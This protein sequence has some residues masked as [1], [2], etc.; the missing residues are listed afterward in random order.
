MAVDGTGAWPL[1]PEPD[2]EF[3]EVDWANAAMA[4]TR[5]RDD[6]IPARVLEELEA[7]AGPEGDTQM[8]EILDLLAWYA[9]LHFFGERWGI[10][11]REDAVLQVAGRIGNRLPRGRITDRA[12]AW[13]AIRSALY[14][15]YFHE[16]FHHYVESFAIR[17]ELIQ[18]VRRYQPYHQTVY[19]QLDDEDEPVEEA[20]ACAAMV[21]RQRTERALRSIRPDVRKATSE[22]LKAWIPSLPNGYKKGLGLEDDGRFKEALARLSSQIQAGST[23]SSDDETRW[24]LVGDYLHQGM[25]KGRDHTY[26][27]GSGSPLSLKKLCLSP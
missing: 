16:A 22:M 1:P 11:I 7:I 19:G 2:T 6:V 21:R 12:T 26:L 13:D 14:T 18:K 5:S 3:V 20:L 8:S 27:V 23:V 4:R 24:R 25:W 15:L 17:L 9:P 10:Y